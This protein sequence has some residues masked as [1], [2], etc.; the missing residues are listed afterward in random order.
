MIEDANPQRPDAHPGAGRELEVLGDAAVEQQALAGIG[1]VGEFQRVA[2]LVVALVVE[3]IAGVLILPPVPRRDVRAPEP[4]FELALVRHQLERDPRQRQADIAGPA[5][6]PGA[7][8]RGRRGLGRAETGDEQD[9]LAGRFGRKRL[10]FVPALLAQRGAG[11]E[12]HLEPGEEVVAQ[13]RVGAELHRQRLE[14]LRHVEIDGR[15]DLA[16]IAHG[17]RHAGRGR[18]AVVDVERAAIGDDQPEIMV[19]AERV[20]PRQPVHDHRRL[21]LHEGE[22]GRKHRLVRRQHAV[23]VDHRLRRAG[24]AGGEQDLGDVV[25][26]DLG[27]RGIDGLA[28]VGFQLTEQLCAARRRILA[29]DQLA[30]FRHCGLDRLAEHRAVRRIDQSGRQQFDDVFELAEVG[31]HQ[32]IGR[33]HRRVGDADIHRGQRQQ[34]VLDAVAGED[35]DRPLGGKVARQQSRRDA[36][37]PRQHLRV[38]Q[39]APFAIRAALRD[40]NAIRRLFRPALQRVAVAR[41]VI[42]ERLLDAEDDRAVALALEHGGERAELHRPQRHFLLCL[43]RQS[44]HRILAVT[45]ASPSVRAFQGKRAAASSPRHRLARSRR[46]ATPSQSRRTDRFR[47]CAAAHA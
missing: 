18:I 25:A 2:Q 17:L 40:E 41:R 26:A 8:K 21:V 11:V 24:R 20:A 29:D 43:A 27:V 32:R 34:R 4:R 47:R 6:I 7:G 22:A 14:A 31:R 37:H 44:R 5:G 46:S 38:S 13:R 10:E 28:V 19:G 39:L 23:G 12:Q 42:A 9:A 35:D 36:A 33:R 1:R 15:R 45:C 3:R 30:I 16:Q